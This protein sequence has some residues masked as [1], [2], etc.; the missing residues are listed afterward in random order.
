MDY[1]TS[2]R[3]TRLKLIGSFLLFGVIVGL[4]SVLANTIL[5]GRN[6]AKS[7]AVV[8]SRLLDDWL[9]ED[10]YSDDP[11]KSSYNIPM[12][13]VSSFLNA[14][15][16]DFPYKNVELRLFD[17][18]EDGWHLHRLDETMENQEALEKEQELSNYREILPHIITL[19]PHTLYRVKSSSSSM[20]WM[21][22]LTPFT[23]HKTV[24]LSMRFSRID[25]WW[26][27]NVQNWRTFAFYGVSDFHTLLHPC[28]C[29]FL[30]ANPFS[31]TNE[32]KSGTFC[33]KETTASPS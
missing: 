2:T 33:P 19:Q 13:R 17:A 21:T 14:L 31:A 24:L 25:Q 7:T 12:Q 22:R 23:G 27:Q 10:N 6:I 16:P 8:I 3:N 28:H 15:P 20:E 30:E 11:H 29:F 26:N 18:K 4:G 5:T 1:R 32:R 9:I